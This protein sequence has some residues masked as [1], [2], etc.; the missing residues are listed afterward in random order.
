LPLHIA[1]FGALLVALD[2]PLAESLVIELNSEDAEP[3]CRDWPGFA[4]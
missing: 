1:D 3:N 2:E 4:I